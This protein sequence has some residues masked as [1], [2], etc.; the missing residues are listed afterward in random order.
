MVSQSDLDKL[1]KAY[2]MKMDA[3]FKKYEQGHSKGSKSKSKKGG[4]TAGDFLADIETCW[5]SHLILLSKF[6]QFIFSHTLQL[7]FKCFLLSGTS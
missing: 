6:E 1:K 7:S 5:D 3:I 4:Q 2:M